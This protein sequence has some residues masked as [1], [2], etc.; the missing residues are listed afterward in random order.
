MSL[1]RAR[2]ARRVVPQR[3][4]SDGCFNIWFKLHFMKTYDGILATPMRVPDVALRR[5]AVGGDARVDL[6]RDVF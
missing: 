1:C 3:R 4:L 5:N 2:T 6:C